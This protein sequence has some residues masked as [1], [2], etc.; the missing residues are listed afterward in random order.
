MPPA[1]RTSSDSSAI[2]CGCITVVV[3]T[4]HLTSTFLRILCFWIWIKLREPL[5][6]ACQAR[7]VRQ[8]ENLL[9]LRE[10]ELNPTS[11]LVV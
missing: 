10:L 5:A 11:M 2:G 9:L 3:L 7:Q 6:D 1:S 8:F 4:D